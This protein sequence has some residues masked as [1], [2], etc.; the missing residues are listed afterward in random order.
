MF[1]LN[2]IPI[3]FALFCLNLGMPIVDAHI[4]TNCDFHFTFD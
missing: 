2:E 1:K 3:A 4:N